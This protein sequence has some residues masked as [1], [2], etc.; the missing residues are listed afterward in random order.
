[1]N[2]ESNSI[3]VKKRLMFVKSE[4]YYYLTYNIF[5][6]LHNLG[7][8]NCE[9][10]KFR[11]YRK[12]AFLI[13]YASDYNLINILENSKQGQSLSAIDKELLTRTYTSGMIMQG[14]LI[15]LLF[16]LENKNFIVLE[17]DDVQSTVNVCLNKGRIP[18]DLF[19]SDIFKPENNNM[20]ILK[21]HLLRLNQL[22]LETLLNKLFDNYGIKR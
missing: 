14:Q 10:R 15:R 11:D 13:E 2:K 19:N 3:E 7:C 8:Y 6:I 1:M 21:K 20:K 5:F 17:K 18:E 16:T 9:K 4:D 22:T 12:L